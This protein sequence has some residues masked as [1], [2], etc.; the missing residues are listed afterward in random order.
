VVRAA[1]A[2][3]VGVVVARAAAAAGVNG[4]DE[5]AS[6][7]SFERVGTFYHDYF[8]QRPNIRFSPPGRY[9][10]SATAKLDQ[11]ALTD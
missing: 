2:A 3:A 10:G 11:P 9:A 6:P 8:G 4:N 1:A 7:F 5:G